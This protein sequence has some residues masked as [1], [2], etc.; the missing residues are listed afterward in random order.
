MAGGTDGEAGACGILA[1]RPAHWQAGRTMP[2]SE[3]DKE[4]LDFEQSW[5]TRPE[6]KAAAIRRRFGISPTQYY[7]Q[8]GELIDDGTALADFP[9]L[10]RRLRRRRLERRRGRYESTP[11]RQNP[12]R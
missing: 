1:S 9:L 11:E 4:I 5:W 8:L 2:L 10:V 12:G 7:R 6:K 3:K